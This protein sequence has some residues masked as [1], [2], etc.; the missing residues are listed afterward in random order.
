MRYYYDFDMAKTFTEKELKQAY[1]E[2]KNHYE[3]GDFDGFLEV[4]GAYMDEISEE[5][6]ESIRQE[7]ENKETYYSLTAILMQELFEN[8]LFNIKELADKYT[9]NKEQKTTLKEL[10]N[11]YFG[12]ELWKKFLKMNISL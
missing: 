5:V 4:E 8:D 12:V 1:E 11:E 3:Y 6:F 7:E 10:Y 9:M 2:N